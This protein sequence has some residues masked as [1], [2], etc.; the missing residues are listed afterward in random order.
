V[1]KS[2]T[3]SK[4]AA[5]QK[6]LIPPDTERC[7]AEFTV[8]QPFIFGGTC[9]RVQRCEEKPV[10]LAVELKPGEDGRCG[11]MSLCLKCAKVILEDASFR[12]RIQLQPI[13]KRN[14]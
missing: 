13:E 11:S 4:G 14:S 12:H 1:K 10:F 8:S 9:R 7:Q 3:K 5:K 2:E 6:P